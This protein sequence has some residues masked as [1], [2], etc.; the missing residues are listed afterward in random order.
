MGL[1]MSFLSMFLESCAQAENEARELVPQISTDFTGKVLIIGAGAAG[2]S[3]AYFLERNNIEY[4]VLEASGTY[5]GRVKR[6][7]DFADFPIDLGA[8]WLHTDPIVLSE[9]LDDSSITDNIELITYN[10]QTYSVWNGKKLSRQNWMN[11]FYSEYKFKSTTWFG[12][13]EKYIIPHIGAKIQYNQA[14]EEINYQ[15]EKIQIKTAAGQTFE[16]DKVLI[17]VPITILQ[18]EMISFNPPLPTNKIDAIKG[19]EM[20][21]GIKVF[22]EFREKF[23]PDM[24]VMGGILGALS[25]SE[26]LYYDAAFGK[27]VEKHVLGLFTVGE[28]ATPY[29]QL[30]NDQAIIDKILGE[31]DEMFEGKA[32]ETYEKHIIQNWSKEP[33]IGGSYPQSY[34]NRSQNIANILEPLDKKVFFAGEAI[35]DEWQ[36]TVNGACESGY[37]VVKNLLG[38]LE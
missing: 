28:N 35:H 11:N 37:E 34:E 6:T 19:V 25:A 15:N 9:I 14:V 5:G 31:L 27:D 36:S 4:E 30:E 17:T 8:E 16:A 38:I 2:M 18:Q 12:F 13:F 26:R 3:A 22:I 21:D 20:G 23:Y 1:G 24:I 7:D 29:A 10:P 32:S 33:F